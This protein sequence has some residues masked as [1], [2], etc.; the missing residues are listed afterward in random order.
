VSNRLTACIPS[1]RTAT[2]TRVRWS[3]APVDVVKVVALCGRTFDPWEA[4][5]LRG[6]VPPWQPQ[7]PPGLCPQ[8]WRL[9]KPAPAP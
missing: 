8:C 7:R 9:H 5:L 6:P 4:R 2:V 1:G 3:T